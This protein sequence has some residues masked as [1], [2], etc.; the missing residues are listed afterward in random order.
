MNMDK[1]SPL[2]RAIKFDYMGTLK[3][4]GVMHTLY[5]NDCLGIIIQTEE[6]NSDKYVLISEPGPVKYYLS[7]D[8]LL[9]NHPI[10]K[11]KA[12]DEYG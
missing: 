7:L 1:G 12:S 10:I 8:K 2:A 11:S 5:M 6:D 3:I 9:G 4:C